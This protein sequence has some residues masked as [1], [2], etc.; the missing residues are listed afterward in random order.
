MRFDVPGRNALV[1]AGVGWRVAA[2]YR[3]LVVAGVNRPTARILAQ[4]PRRARTD[5]GGRA[6]AVTSGRAG[7]KMSDA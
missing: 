4:G 7:G 1:R 2:E 5:P 6:P 3:R